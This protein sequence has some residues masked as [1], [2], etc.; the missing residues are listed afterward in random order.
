MTPT[1]TT[2]RIAVIG[3]TGPQGKGLG[4]RFAR[5]GHTVVIGSRAMEKAVPAAAEVTER[6]AGVAGAGEVSGAANAD[7]CADADVVLL[8]VPYDGHDELVATLPLAGKI[9]V[10]CVNPLAST[11]PVPT[12]GS[13]TAVKARPPSRPS[14]SR[15]TR[16]WSAPSTT[17]RR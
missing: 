7:A 17:S 1:D 4:Y 15:R 10:S 6:L 5:H 3:G 16:R 11:R 8:A 12:A 13:S 2:Y 14:G 9:V